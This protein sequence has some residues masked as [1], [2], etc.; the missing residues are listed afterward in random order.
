MLK[1]IDSQ[2]L[3]MME[4]MGIEDEVFTIIDDERIYKRNYYGPINDIEEYR[5]L[6]YGEAVDEYFNET[7]KLDFRQRLALHTLTEYY[8]NG[9]N[10]VDQIINE[11]NIELAGHY[12]EAV[13]SYIKLLEKMN[14]ISLV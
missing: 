1:Y 2:Y 4:Y 10:C 11:V 5:A 6:G 13:K 7:K 14:K 3:G 12:D 8:I 9:K